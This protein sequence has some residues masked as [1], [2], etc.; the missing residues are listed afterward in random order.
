MAQDL[1]GGCFPGAIEKRV[2]SEQG[3]TLTLA[4]THV[5]EVPTSKVK[6][7]MEQLCRSAVSS[8]HLSRPTALVDEVLEAWLTGR[9]CLPF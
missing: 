4:E 6:A 5:K 7:I 2:R 9:K 3:L 8:N 1:E